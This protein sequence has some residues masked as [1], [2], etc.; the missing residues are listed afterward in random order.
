MLRQHDIAACVEITQ[1]FDADARL[2]GPLDPGRNPV[3]RPADRKGTVGKGGD[4][5]GDLAESSLRNVV[6][7]HAFEQGEMVAAVELSVCGRIGVM[8]LDEC[9][10]AAEFRLRQPVVKFVG[11]KEDELPIFLHVTLLVF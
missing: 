5:L 4:V 11:G 8:V 9:H 1:V 2:V 10:G 7:L 6:P 3:Q